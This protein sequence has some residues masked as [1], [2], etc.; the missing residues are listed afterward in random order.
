MCR[1]CGKRK[2]LSEFYG[3]TRP[4]CK[5]CYSKDL[6]E[7]NERRK[8]AI[9]KAKTEQLGAIS[10]QEKANAGKVLD[11]PVLWFRATPTHLMDGTRATVAGRRDRG[12]YLI[13]LERYLEP[14]QRVYVWV[15]EVA[16]DSLR[17]PPMPVAPMRVWL[18]AARYTQLSG[19]LPAREEVLRMDKMPDKML[20][21]GLVWLS[22]QG[23]ARE[24]DGRV[25]LHY[26]PHPRASYERWPGE[27]A[28][29][30]GDA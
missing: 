11:T 16:A 29:A 2:A 15:V 25:M 4:A 3:P 17:R 21:E 30:V 10:A 19:E 7:L 20:D 26:W 12:N 22:E 14:A 8:A 28:S 18:A 1:H 27:L 13:L 5:A 9:V 24:R 6:Y 23:Y